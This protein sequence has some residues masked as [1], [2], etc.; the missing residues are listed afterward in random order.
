[1]GRKIALATAKEKVQQLNNAS[2]P[3]GAG[4]SSLGGPESHA[5]AISSLEG[6]L[7]KFLRPSS[8]GGLG[9]GMQTSSNNNQAAVEQSSNHANNSIISAAVVSKSNNPVAVVGVAA[10]AVV[11]EEQKL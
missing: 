1:M 2:F 4:L 10:T 6:G 11:S 8:K 5:A 3:G 7:S 9:S